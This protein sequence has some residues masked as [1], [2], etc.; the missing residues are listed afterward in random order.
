[1]GRFVGVSM[2]LFV[3][4][5][6]FVV[7][8][9]G[10][11]MAALIGGLSS[12]PLIHKIAW[13]VVV[14]VPLAMV[15]FAVWLWDR[16]VR[17]RQAAAALELRLN[18]VRGN[19]RELAS[20][21]AETD[22]DV[23]RLARSDPEDAIAALQRRIGDAERAA[24][25]QEGRNQMGDLESRVEVIRAQ[26]HKLKERLAPV[27]ET[28]RTIEQLFAELDTRHDDIDR[29][30]AEIGSG[31]D[32]TTLELRLKN[33]A[34]FVHQSNAR[35]DQIEQ[36]SKTIAM[37]N[38]LCTELGARL[39]PFTAADDGI[40]VRLRQL[41]EQ[42]DVLAANIAALERTPTG[43]LAESVQKIADDGRKLDDGITQ[44]NVQFAK[45]ASL[46]KDAAGLF[47]GFDRALDT[48]ALTKSGGGAAAIDKRI[49]ELSRFIEQTRSKL[50]DVER[51]LASFSQLRTRLDELQSRL[52]PLASQDSGVIRL[53]EELHDR[54]ET[55]TAKIR[56]IEGGGEGELAARVQAFAETKREL[57]ERVAAL[58]DQ[59]ARLATIRKDI[60]GLF[61]K[62]A[63]TAGSA[64]S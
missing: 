43:S 30:L 49:D 47:A 50:D 42:R 12:E 21:Q 14:L 25:L 13:L 5:V 27:L 59:F 10:P 60:A 58:S 3:L 20:V 34:E 33:F 61:D 35:C 56:H 45:L 26:Q 24:Q 46:R 54:R 32:G 37:L 53:I 11:E 31:D 8:D 15:P 6:G 57:E 55:L 62:L 16:L 48:L 28:R 63:S 2:V 36:A 29:A 44:L 52:G 38:E 4:A 23:Q 39:A 19:V 51:H 41:G 18:G 9:Q 40:A 64:A 22:A 17:E 1:M 7:L